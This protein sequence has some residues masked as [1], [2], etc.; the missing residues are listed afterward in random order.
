M[1]SVI[2][3]SPTNATPP[4]AFKSAAASVIRDAARISRASPFAT[5]SET[6]RVRSRVCWSSANESPSRSSTGE[7]SM[8][9]GTERGTEATVSLEGV[10]ESRVC[11]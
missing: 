11:V 10:T 3:P 5:L 1:C 7:V 4:S 6:N 8:P 9:R 2:A